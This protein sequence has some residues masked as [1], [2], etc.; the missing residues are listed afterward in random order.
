MAGR[1]NARNAWK[2][3]FLM[4]QL[5]LIWGGHFGTFRVARG[6][7]W[8]RSGTRSRPAGATA[9]AQNLQGSDVRGQYSAASLTGR[10]PDSGT[11][12]EVVSSRLSCEGSAAPV[13][14]VEIQG[15]R[16]QAEG[17]Q[18]GSRGAGLRLPSVHWLGRGSRARRGRVGH[19]EHVEV[20]VSCR[21]TAAA[22][23]FESKDACAF[24]DYDRFI[25]V[26]LGADD[27]SAPRWK[28]VPRPSDP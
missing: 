5:L 26:R 19:L 28:S 11:G 4:H 13:R 25:E 9:T 20:S 16:R 23:T 21:R 10:G 27:R 1:R 24:A 2:T 12:N 14:R 18:P 17:V 8:H 7:F 6:G 3:A 15:R 22:A